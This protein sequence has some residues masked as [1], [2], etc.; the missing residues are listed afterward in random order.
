MLSHLCGLDV[1][2][3]HSIPMEDYNNIRQSLEGFVNNIEYPITKII[4][5]NGK[6]YGF[7]LTYHKSLMV[8]MWTS[9]GQLNI[10]EIGL[11]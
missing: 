1:K 9:S 10:D 3:L 11:R 2:Y 8:H 5:I 7:V 6:E 4:T